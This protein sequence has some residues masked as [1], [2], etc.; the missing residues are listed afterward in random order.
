MQP[1]ILIHVWTMNIPDGT[2]RLFALTQY[3]FGCIE[4]SYHQWCYTIPGSTFLSNGL[5]TII[6]SEIIRNNS[7]GAISWS[8]SC[9][10]RSGYDRRKTS[11]SC[12]SD[13]EL[14]HRRCFE[15]RIKIESLDR[16]PQCVYDQ[17]L[18]STTVLNCTLNNVTYA[19]MHSLIHALTENNTDNTI[20]KRIEHG[21][22]KQQK[23]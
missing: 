23:A 18:S 19:D 1:A 6:S 15:Q 3:L 2:E 9:H 17:T 13:G 22:N 20:R 12:R 16:W 10:G 4:S 14:F 5:N 7:T 11:W 21:H 8:F